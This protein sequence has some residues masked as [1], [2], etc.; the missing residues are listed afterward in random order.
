MGWGPEWVV[1]EDSLVW[2]MPGS[3]QVPQKSLE[4]Y[5]DS[6]RERHN[7]PEG[8]KGRIGHK[9]VGQGWKHGG[10]WGNYARTTFDVFVEGYTCQHWR[11]PH[12]RAA[13]VCAGHS[14]PCVLDL[15][16]GPPAC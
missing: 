15:N 2:M 10:I 7:M 3:S 8:K 9:C 16:P 6:G 4:H 14:Q 5:Q 1:W 11:A 12:S 13:V